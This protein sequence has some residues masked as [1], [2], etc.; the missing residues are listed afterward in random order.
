MRHATTKT[1]ARSATPAKPPSARPARSRSTDGDVCTSGDACKTG[2]CSGQAKD[3]KVDCNDNN[4]CTEDVC[5]KKQGCLNKVISTKCDDGNPCTKDDTCVCGKCTGG[6][7][8]CGCQK[9]KDCASQEDGN[10]CNGTLFCDTAKAPFSC[11]ID[12]KSVI[13]CPTDQN[14]ACLINRCDKTKGSC[15]LHPRNEGGNCDADGS[16]CTQGDKCKGGVCQAGA[17]Q[18]C[19]DKNPCTTDVCD[20]K[21]GC[22]QTA[23]ANA[24]DDGNLCTVGSKC[25]AKLCQKG[26]A[27]DCNDKDACTTDFCDKGNGKCVNKPIVGC[28]GNCKSTSDCKDNNPCTNDSCLTGKCLFENNTLP[29]N[30]NNVCTVKDSCASGSCVGQKNPCGDNN[31]C[32][33]DTCDPATGC[34]HSANTVPCNDGDQCTQGDQCNGGLCKSGKK[35]TCNDSDNC[36][37]DSCN[38]QTGKCV[39]TPVIGCGGNCKKT[40]DCQDNNVCTDNSCVGGKCKISNNV[41]ACDDKNPCTAIDKC[42]NGKCGGGAGVDVKTVAGSS[43]GYQDGSG[44]SA[45]FKSPYDVVY[46]PKTA[47]IYIADTTNHRIRR[48]NQAGKVETVAGSGSSSHSDGVGT[49]ARFNYPRGIA[50][51]KSGNIYVADTNNHRIRKVAAN[52]LVTTIA[53]SGSSTWGDG[54]GTSARFDYPY[55][56][57]A[58]AGGTLYVA[59]RNSHRIRRV[60]PDG[61]VTTLAGSSPGY[62]DGVG[63]QARFYSPQDVEVSADGFVYVADYTNHRIRRVSPAG[64]VTTVAGTTQ[65][66]KDGPAT[67]ARLNSPKALAIDSAGNLFFAGLGNRRVRKIDPN[68]LV[69]TVAGSGQSGSKDGPGAIA[70]F[71]QLMGLAV[72]PQG[73]IYVADASTHRIRRIVDTTGNCAVK[74]I[75]YAAGSVNPGNPCQYCNAKASQTSWSVQGKGAPCIDG[76][77]CSIKETCDA[78]GSCV[79]QPNA[80]EDGNKCTKDACDKGTGG[81]SHAPIVGCGGFCNVSGDCNDGNTCTN[82]ACVSHKCVFTNNSNSCASGAKCGGKGTCSLGQCVI[83]DFVEV[84][85][86]A[87]TGSSTFQDGPVKIAKFDYPAGTAI[88]NQGR[89]L[90]AD[91]RTHRIRRI[92]KGN[93]ETIAGSGS[94]SYADGIGLKAHFNYPY[95]LDVDAK[96]TIY[97]ADRNN[98]RIRRVSSVGLVTTMAGTGSSSFQDGAGSSAR[99]SSPTDV[100]VTKGGVVFVADSSNHRIR[101]VIPDGTVTTVAGSGSAKWQDGK[102]TAASFSYPTGIDITGNGELFVADRNNRR[103]RRISPS[104]DVTTVAGTGGSNYVDGPSNKA[105]FSY[106]HAVAVDSGGTLYV[107][108]RYRLRRISV[109]GVVKSL[110]GQSGGGFKDG[111][112]LEARFNDITGVAVDRFGTVWLADMNNH[113]IRRVHDTKDNCAFS[114]GCYTPGQT[115]ATN[116]CK[117]CAPKQSTTKWTTKANQAT[118]DDGKVCTGEDACDTKGVC[119][120]EALVCND[121][122][123]CTK[124]SCDVAV[125]GCKFVP[126]IGCGGNCETVKHCDD[127]NECTNEKCLQGKCAYTNNAKDCS[128]GKVCV[129]LGSC[130]LGK[131][132]VA[133]ATT[134]TTLAGSGSNGWQDGPPKTARFYSPMGMDVDPKGRVLVA[135]YQNHRLRRI[136]TDGK[137]VTVAGSGSSS[138]KD[139]V[140]TGAHLG[141]P[142]DVASDAKGTMYVSSYNHHRIRK[143]SAAG[144]VSTFAGSGSSSFKDGQGTS[145]RFN[146]PRGIAST[147]DGVVYVADYG[148]HR[149]RRI[150]PD[151]TVTTLAGSGTA[152]ALDGIGAKARFQYPWGLDIDSDGNLYVCSQHSRKIRRVTPEGQVTTIAGSGSS[153]YLDGPALKARFTSPLD[154]EVDAQGNVYISDQ[155]NRRIRRLSTNGVVT[156][157]AGSNNSGYLDGPA[158]LARFSSIAGLAIDH[159]GRVLVS[160]QSTQRIRRVHDTSNNCEIGGLCYTAGHANPQNPCQQCDAAKNKTSWSARGDGVGCDDNTLCTVKETCK[161]GKCGATSKTCNDGDK[162]T[163]D[164]CDKAS[165]ACVFAPIVGCDGNCNSAKDCDDSNIC[166]DDQCL[167]GKCVQSFNSKPC[168]SG[169]VCS[170]GDSCALGKCVPG[171]QV[172]V[173]TVAGT[174]QQGFTDGKGTIAKLRD[175]WGVD[176]DSAGNLY[177]AD[178]GNHRIRRLDTKG[179]LSTV[180]GSGSSTY[181]DGIGQGASFSNPSD[182]SVDAGG[183]LFIADTSNHR[184]RKMNPKGVVSTVTNGGGGFKDG[185]AGQAKFSSPGSLVWSPGNVIFVSDT[186]NHRVRRIDKDGTVSTLAGGSNGYK[187]GKGAAARLYYPWGIDIGPLGNLYVADSYNHRIR[188]I[189]PDGTVTTLAGSGSSSF[190]NG[191]YLSARFNY[192]RG[193]A[194]DSAGRIFVGDTSNQRLR[195]LEGGVVST[196]AGAGGG[197]QDGVGSSARFSN[198]YGIA[199]DK[200]GNI[201]VADYSNHRVRR[202]RDSKDSCL[203]GGR[204]WTSGQL[205]PDKKCQSCAA[206]KSATTWTQQSANAKC[207]DGD[208]C[209]TKDTCDAKGACNGA[210]TKCDDNDKCT[211]DFCDKSTGSCRATPIVKCGGNC[212][213]KS[214]CDDG[215][216]CT[217][218]ACINLK[219][220]TTFNAQPCKSGRVCSVGDTCSQGKCVAG[221]EVLVSHVAGHPNGSP[222]FAD[223]NDP[224]LAKFHHIFGLDVDDSG[225]VFVADSQNSRIRRVAFNGVVSTIAGNTQG[226][227]DGIGLGAKFNYPHD[228][229]VAPG[230]VLY[231]ADTNNNRIRHIATNGTV[232]TLAGASGGFKDGTGTVARFSNPRGIAINLGGTLYVADTSNNRI[233]LVSPKGVVTTLAGSGYGYK[234]GPGSSAQFKSPRGLDVDASGNVYVADE[235]NYRI[236]KVTPGGV[237]STLAGSGSSS[238]KDA[239]GKLAGFNGPRGISV[240]LAG[241]IWVGDS[242]RVRKIAPNGMV[243]SI[244]GGLGN[245]KLETGQVA[246]F[247]NVWAVAAD[248]HGYVYTAEYTG[249]RIRRVW[250]SKNNCEIGKQCYAAGI[251]NK[252]N[253]CQFC[254]AGQADTKW[255]LKGSGASCIDDSLCTAKDSCDSNG[256]CNGSKTKCDDGDKCTAD[257]CDAATGGCIFKPIIGCGNNCGT[258]KD[259]EDNNLCT[260][261]L[262]ISGKCQFTFNAKP[263]KSGKTCSV[264]DTC[265]QGKCVAGE[266]VGVSTVAGDGNN[267][268]KDGDVKTARFYNPSGID[269]ADDGT[270]WVADEQ[271]HRIRKI[272]GG[273]VVTFAGSGASSFADGI[274]QGAKFNYPADI[275]IG[276]SGVLYVADRNNNRIRKIATN[277]TVTTL[278]GQSS[279]GHSDGKGAGARFNNPYGLDVNSQGVILVADT[280]NHRIR[281]VYPNGD[282][283]TVAGSGSSTFK[284]GT[285]I[286]SSFNYPYDIA[287]NADGIAFVADANNHRIRRVTPSGVVTTVAGTGSSSFQ[288]GATSV[289]RFNY[290]RGIAIDNAGN[291][292]VGD[293]SNNRIRRIAPNNVVSTLAGSNGGFTDGVGSSARFSQPRGLAIDIYGHIYVADQ[294]NRRIR[295]VRNSKGACEI[296]G[297]CYAAGI[298]S[299]SD[300]CKQCNA[301]KSD[302]AW[303]AKTA[304]TSCDDGKLCTLDDKCTAGGTCGGTKLACPD[305]GGCVLQKCLAT[306]GS[307]EYDFINNTCNAQL[308]TKASNSPGSTLGTL[309]GK[310]GKSIR[311][312]KLGVCG[313]SDGGSGPNR[314]K[315]AGGGINFTWAAGRTQSSAGADHWLGLTPSLGGSA[316]GWVYKDAVYKA[317]AG[318]SVTITFDYHFDWDGRYC[319]QKDIAGVSYSDAASTVRAWLMYTYD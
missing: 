203:I 182:I 195:K 141:Y 87:G 229:V 104:G 292:Y 258:A 48:M 204:C 298:A 148:N 190:Q 221:Q 197:F 3:P 236:R 136:E 85:T 17:L 189:T 38:A 319:A 54:Q 66:F 281:R 58:T 255:T 149:I 196:L 207:N 183:N 217:D 294:S 62:K 265:H 245:A 55:G 257:S 67:L 138:Y 77:L 194:V 272:S 262:C 234:D 186:N 308:W 124:D 237:V 24:C 128:V 135:D 122:D 179:I 187:D 114:D 307:C 268:F 175:P 174:S 92:N 130:A 98:H 80:C 170:A 96:G 143:I 111:V 107:G 225:N 9:D 290:P 285:G 277:G 36:T 8:T 151:R 25:A 252:G 32:T 295:Q 310:A 27:K 61:N 125:G 79:G 219:C 18:Q 12:P 223:A 270:I 46:E 156:T 105:Q 127:S 180:A 155:G 6:K 247:S 147:G 193:I 273:K 222:G 302:K 109:G 83:F 276:P 202:V 205:N 118:C 238:Y 59:G 243:T 73:R 44:T 78:K 315:A 51:D 213:D 42:S 10:A 45:R 50:A 253:T 53:G 227:A 271:N 301:A 299:P 216:L 209:T 139:G 231:V 212:T 165:G 5:D 267:G 132:I 246:N 33:T 57:T 181:K 188:R 200:Y 145:A 235:N 208:L 312:L 113:R 129:A 317:A 119:A 232:T 275:A 304:G 306:T 192:P 90:I 121:G 140:G 29:C 230:G 210:V 259:C 65:G 133:D 286:Q 64:V 233:R 239:V 123:K 288:D 250:D 23:N 56:I 313:D 260:D 218:D 254:N 97:V 112:G 93:V 316:R 199:V 280:S 249:Y 89:V 84:S 159:F 63:A 177:I 279:G 318:A 153:G 144:I 103:I 68:G 164:S 120:G 137:V 293:S 228:V 198:P 184:I 185:P 2:K 11:K 35:K 13:K 303:S 173:S 21:A 37:T 215:N 108:D 167:K 191:A 314:F 28:G 274:G 283:E 131:C 76:D 70:S 34:K 172:L 71:Q 100:A 171:V 39:F 150:R 69:S 160:D 14:S 176:A 224:K 300:T 102:G 287:V 305:T 116:T 101:R 19:D 284:D 134:V 117:A 154:V 26:K 43:Y 278:A 82:D 241:N 244:A 126:I 47:M 49:N 297:K 7:N 251:V 296:G 146:S 4:P 91:S 220:A 158:S 110:A 291:I 240:D 1:R 30:D 226:W 269:V 31:Q 22:K 74:G 266:A 72:D 161:S 206:G 256:V 166:T 40:A 214:H 16:V 52:G 142:W 261:D 178:R 289:A 282:V 88:D 264:G 263:C 163:K 201:F 162:C 309:P 115:S 157:F 211:S 94:S 99:F 60:T 41:K 75:C 168:D 152:Q 242:S 311:I 81:C 86:A 169:K 15:K 248:R 106:P 20:K 95:G